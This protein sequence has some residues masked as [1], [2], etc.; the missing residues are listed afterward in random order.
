MERTID[1]I[2]GDYR[3]TLSALREEERLRNDVIQSDEYIDLQTKIDRLQA[4]QEALM[5][6]IPDSSE[7]HAL[8]KAELLQYMQEHKCDHVGEF[9]AK[10]RVKRRVDVWGVFN[11]LGGDLDNLV[12]LASITQ[13]ALEKWIKD[14]PEDKRGLRKCIIEDGV[15]YVDILPIE[16]DE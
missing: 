16:S 12:L 1:Q 15:Q 9:R 14:N 13:T 8:D 11:A 10:T 6:G 5:A 2:L 7:E 4:Q 3:A